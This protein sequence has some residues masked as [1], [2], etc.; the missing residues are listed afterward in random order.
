MKGVIQ[1]PG[2]QITNKGRVN[3]KNTPASILVQQVHDL[4]EPRV[5]SFN[6]GVLAPT[7]LFESVRAHR[8]FP[9]YARVNGLF[10]PPGPGPTLELPALLSL[11]ASSK[12]RGQCTYM[13]ANCT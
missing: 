12:G 8:A 3:K 5:W 11:L 13:R 10:L 4:T 2:C 1:C 7:T 9:P 6:T